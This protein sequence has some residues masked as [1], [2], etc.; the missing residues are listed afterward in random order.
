MGLGFTI[1][2]TAI[3][4]VR[5]IS[6][7]GTLF[8][9]ASLLLGPPSRSIELRLLPADTGVLMMILPPGGFLVT[10]LLVVVKRLLDLR[11]AGKEI[12]MAPGST[13]PDRLTTMPRP[14]RDRRHRPRGACRRRDGLAR[15]GT[16]HEPAAAAR[17]PR[18]AAGY[19]DRD[20]HG[21]QPQSPDGASPRQPAAFASANAWWSVS[22]DR[23]LIKASLTAYALPLATALTA[24]GSPKGR[25]PATSSTMAAM[26]GG[27][28]PSA[29][30]LRA[31]GAP[32]GLA[33]R[34]GTALPA[35]RR[36]GPS[37]PCG[38]KE[39]VA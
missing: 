17:R 37:K 12:Q 1:A 9:D 5:E 7:N 14:C 2:L 26:A 35:P 33:R 13:R 34:T 4:A 21:R 16:D 28:W 3:G 31:S 24:G 11:I 19:R 8:A 15:A 25:T 6:G 22:I 20:R 23:A 29:S 36:A 39:S 32:A 38:T 27:P 18:V 10:G 30:W